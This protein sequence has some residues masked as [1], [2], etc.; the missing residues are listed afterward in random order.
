MYPCFTPSHKR[1]K[2]CQLFLPFN[3]ILKEE[4][5]HNVGGPSEDLS[6]TTEL[7]N[8]FAKQENESPNAFKE[9]Q[10]KY[11]EE[12]KKAAEKK[13]AMKELN[14]DHKDVDET[15]SAE[16]Q[17]KILEEIKKQRSHGGGVHPPQDDRHTIGGC[18]QNNHQAAPQ[19]NLQSRQQHFPPADDYSGHHTPSNQDR[20][21]HS[22]Q[23]RNMQSQP[24]DPPAVLRYGEMRSQ[25][26]YP[27]TKE[28]YPD[29]QQLSQ[30]DPNHYTGMPNSQVAAA[31]NLP[32]QH[33]DAPKLVY[34]QP[35]SEMVPVSSQQYVSSGTHYPQG[36]QYYT[37]PQNTGGQY[38]V[39]Q[40][41]QVPFNNPGD[42][43]FMP[44]GGAGIP[45][46]PV[47]YQ[48]PYPG[49]PQWS[50]NY[51]SHPAVREN[52]PPANVNPYNLEVGS[53]IQYGHNPTY[54]GVI[55]WIGGHMAGVEMVSL[56][57]LFGPYNVRY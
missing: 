45:P 16:A 44:A 15:M 51:T 42:N 25:N 40:Y 14:L 3:C 39:N 7:A 18:H 53:M 55:R 33:H 30:Y 9:Q 20:N 8:Q 13:I 37:H 10:A 36:E 32:Q 2:N 31:A 12:S 35:F 4:A 46:H 21:M 56:H 5:S 11:F 28:R 41:G 54:T 57:C 19:H 24:Q 50:E 1:G 34:E 38:N 49:Q 27:N 43:T 23:D 17:A 47:P 26:Q 29:T 6:I 22:N 48:Q 52:I